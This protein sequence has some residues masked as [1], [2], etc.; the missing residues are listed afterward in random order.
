M[1]TDYNRYLLEKLIP[2][3]DYFP[4]KTSVKQIAAGLK[5]LITYNISKDGDLNLDYGGG[6][7]ELGTEFLKQ[8]GVTNLVYDKYSRSEEH[9]NQVLSILKNRKVDTVT[10]LNVINVN[11]DVEERKSIIRDAYSYLKVGGYMLIMV[12]GGTNPEAGLTKAK[13]WQENRNLQSYLSEI[14]EAIP[15]VNHQ[16]IVNTKKLMIIHKTDYSVKEGFELKTKQGSSIKRYKE[17]GKKMGDDLYF[18]KMYVD[19]YVDLNFYNKLKSFLPEG[20]QFNIIKYNDK[21][22]TISF[23]NSPDFDRA[24]EPIVGD[25]I[26]VREDGTITMTRQKRIPQI[27]HHKWLFVKDDYKGFDINKSKKRSEEW[28]Q[29]SDKINMSKIGTLNYWQD[30]VIPML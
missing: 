23:I 8:H 1:I 10:L 2:N 20:F 22:K 3:V 7:Y 12:Y 21:F 29:V 19:E 28:L 11:E 16:I 18:H 17:V 26:K 30:V 24:D 14:Q 27:Y 5:D 9:N 13:T 25:A 6:K 15:N 4:G